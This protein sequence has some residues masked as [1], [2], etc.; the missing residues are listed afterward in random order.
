M[1]NALRKLLMLESTPTGALSLESVKTYYPHAVDGDEI[2]YQKIVPLLVQSLK[3]FKVSVDTINTVAIP[4]L[5]NQIEELRN[6][7]NVT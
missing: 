6:G 2:N 7:R 3:D 4:H 1:D 5:Q